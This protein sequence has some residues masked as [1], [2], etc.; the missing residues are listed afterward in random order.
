MKTK[1]IL[2][3][4]LAV[5]MLVSVV[6][7][8]ATAAEESSYVP[9]YDYETPVVLVHGI[10]QNDTY[11]LDENGNRQLA[12]D[13]SYLNGWPLE[14][15]VEAALKTILPKLLGSLILRRDLGLADV[16]KKGAAELL[17]AIHKDNEGN[18]INNI[19]VPCFR[20]SM[21]E[22][23]PEMKE[24]CYSRIPVQKCG[25]IIGEDK[26]F[27]FGYD[28]LGDIETNT[29]SLHEYIHNVVIPKT[30]AK[31]INLCPISLGGSVAVSYLGMYKEDYDIIK[32]IVYVVPAI[33]GSDIVGGLLAGD[34]SIEDDEAL[35]FDLLGMLMGD[36]YTTYLVNM[37]LRL[38][39]KNILKTALYALVDGAVET[40]IRNTTQLWATCPTKY[41]LAAREKWLSDDEHK[42]IRDK[43]DAFMQHRADFEK[44]QNE[45]ISKG[46]SVYDVVC[47]DYQM[48]PLVSGYKTCNSDGIIQCTSTSMGATFADL[49][50]TLGDG[51]VAK[52][53]YCNKPGHNHLS[54]D[55]MVDPTTGLLPCTTWY[56][57]GQSHEQLQHNDVCLSLATELMI[58]DNMIDVYSNPAAY[59]QYNGER[60][61]RNVDGMIDDYNK[62]DKSTLGEENCTAIENAIAAVNAEKENTIID[63]A[64]W[65]EV[66]K[67]LE[68]AMI[69][70]GLREKPKSTYLEDGFTKLTKQMNLTLNKIMK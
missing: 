8:G 19:E 2:S 60:Y 56:F 41:Y 53:T 11:V 69:A 4:L 47:Y 51:Y 61:V 6:P 68:N 26:V 70:A 25:Q 33:D 22:M 59:P 30:G 23:T 62:A 18:Y 34:L 66:E 39:P 27:Y 63:E 9:S 49:G 36:S 16:M 44:N 43:V 10:G 55:G 15:N 14:V 45:L 12:A 28:S 50:T 58:D 64:K 65:T 54:P 13:G 52:G 38:L 35:Y 3:V 42:V 48:F 29:K 40:A 67:N 5:L 1:R 17:F 37:L 24:F 57:K 21:A 31:K 20:G 32:N 7:F 46:A